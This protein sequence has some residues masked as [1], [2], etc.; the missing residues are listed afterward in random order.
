[1]HGLIP[2]FGEGTVEVFPV[3]VER[4]QLRATFLSELVV[5][6]GRARF[7]LLPLIVHEFFAPQ[8]AEEGI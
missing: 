7:G 8:L 6:A 5:L 3:I 4:R 2:K 1:L